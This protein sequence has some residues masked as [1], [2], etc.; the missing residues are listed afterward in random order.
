MRHP[1]S[2]GRNDSEGGSGVSRAATATMG[3][4]STGPGSR[5][6]SSLVPEGL[7]TK[8]R[9]EK[10]EPPP[11]LDRKLSQRGFHSRALKSNGIFH[12]S[13]LKLATYICIF[14]NISCFSALFLK[15]IYFYL[16]M[17]VLGLRFCA[18]AFL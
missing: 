6:V 14:L 11:L 7:G 5:T 10:A 17:A 16:F 4:E 1:S 15:F 9:K 8:F 3:P 13:F 12:S 18:R 2:T